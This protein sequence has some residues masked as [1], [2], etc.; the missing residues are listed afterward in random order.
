MPECD[1]FTLTIWSL[2][3]PIKTT[4][5]T[6]TGHLATASYYLHDGSEQPSLFGEAEDMSNERNA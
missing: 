6:C 3:G 4:S 1:C 2:A 5:H